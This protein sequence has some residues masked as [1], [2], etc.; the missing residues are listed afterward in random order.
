MAALVARVSRASCPPRRT[1]SGDK[2]ASAPTRAKG[3]DDPEPTWGAE[4]F[5]GVTFI[6]NPTTRSQNP[7]RN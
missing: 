6:L 4:D 2:L 5:C 1:L 3:E 7:Q